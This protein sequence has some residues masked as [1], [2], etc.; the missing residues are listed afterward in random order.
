MA[1]EITMPRL[2]DSMEEGTIL[3]WLV[4]EGDEVTPGQPLV[5][6]ETDK[7]TV[8]HEALDAG[9]I[10]AITA[11]EGASVA[12]GAA[13]AVVGAAGEDP[14]PPAPAT[15][16]LTPPAT[17]PATAPAGVSAGTGTSAPA[18]PTTAAPT[19][20]NGRP[21]ASP[22]ARRI[23][24][25]AGLSLSGLTGSG[26]QGRVIRADVERALA[27]AGSEGAAAAQPAELGAAAASPPAELGAKGE[28]LVIDLSRTQETVARRMAASRATVPDIELRI[29]V[30][31]GEAVALR[32]QLRE[33]TDP[34]P[35]INDLV[36]KACALALREFPRVN[37]AYHDGRFELFSRINVGIA[38]A[39]ED[40][41]V[42][43]TVTDAD[44]KSLGEI[45]Q[46]TR[47]LAARVRDGQISP[48][49]LAGGTFT[50]SNLGMYGVDSFSAV[51]NQPQAAILTVGA[52]RCRPVVDPEGAIVA[53]PTVILTL[54][55]D[56]RILYGA[57]G[58]RFLARVRALLER[59]L[60]LLVG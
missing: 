38:V 34:L 29:E 59:P 4:A 17:A 58:A 57:D 44:A 26:P 2:S 12:V 43:P 22:L 31:M 24:A 60:A 36:V 14:P 51:I 25:E 47:Q 55:C 11:A 13:I 6:V 16:A 9:V 37:G 5:E 53:R 1:T 20:H 50:V 33:L 48:A 30:D 27:G 7:A 45:A 18:A 21:K 23:A 54:A 10:L 39:A 40:A 28:T 3:R 49:E 46:A 35:T 56:H 52:L 41:L 42:V 15:A 32:E 8:V 19:T